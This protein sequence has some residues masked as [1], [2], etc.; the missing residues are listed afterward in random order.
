MRTMTNCPRSGCN[1]IIVNQVI[2]AHK[3]HESLSGL[4]GGWI[5]EGIRFR[6]TY[7]QI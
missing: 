6:T 3:N 4:L 5:H 2:V 1:G 7:C